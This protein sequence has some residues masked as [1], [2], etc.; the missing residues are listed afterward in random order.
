MTHTVESLI[1]FESRVKDEWEAGNLP[2][3][4]HLCGGNEEQLLEIFG[5]IR[6]QDWVFTSHRAHYHALLKGLTE[7]EVFDYIRSDRSMFIFSRAKRFYQSAIL[8]GCCGIAVGVARAIKEWGEDAR[9]YVF[10][11]DG[12]EEEGGFYEA[13]LY[14]SGHNLPVTFFIEDNNLQVDTP[15]FLRRGMDRG[16]LDGETCVRRYHYKPKFPHA[17]SGCATQIKFNRTHPL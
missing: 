17:G 5:K 6:E 7:D 12:A 2:S 8:G 1:A 3:L 4:I 15:K 14:V 10:L 11:G 9:V 16:L 13:V